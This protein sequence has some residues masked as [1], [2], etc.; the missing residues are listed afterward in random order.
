MCRGLQD[1]DDCALCDQGSETSDH[2]LLSCVYS[3][4]TRCHVFRCSGIPS[5]APASNDALV[6][7]DMVTAIQTAA[8]AE[9]QG[10]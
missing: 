7:G 5:A 9:F 10:G 2:L 3:R 6:A 1:C 4:K 8:A